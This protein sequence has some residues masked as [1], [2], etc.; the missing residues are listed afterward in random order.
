MPVYLPGLTFG[1]LGYGGASYGYSPYGSGVSP[2]L[3]VPVEGGYGG[4]PYGYASYGSVDITPPQATGANALDGYR[5]EVFFSEAMA[6]DAGLINPASYAFATTYGVSIST[7]SVAKGT[8]SGLGYSSVIVTHTGSTLGGQH[9]LTITGLT[10]VA[11]NPIGPSPANMVVFYALGDTA[12]A[13]ASLPLPDDGRS[14]QLDFQNSLGGAQAMLPEADF[15][16][17]V[18][19]LT[20]YVISTTYPVAPVIGSATQ[21]LALPSRVDLDVH[22]MTSAVYDL[23]LGPSL[24]FDYSGVLLPDDDPTLTGVEVGTGTSV[25]TMSDGLLLTKAVGVQYG[26]SFGDTTGRM[27][28]GTT[29][30]MDF[31]FDLTGTSIVPAVFNSTLATMS[32]SDG[33]IQVDL[34]L[35]DSAG[36]KT[37]TI[38]SGAYSATVLAAWDT[39]GEHTV[40][41]ARN[42]KGVFYTVLF[43]GEPLNTFA[44]ASA[45]GAAVFGPGAAFVLGTAHTV[46]VFKLKEI[47][48]TA[49]STL[50]TSAWNFIHGLTAPFTGSAVLTRDKIVTRYGPLVRG[51]GDNTPATKEDVEVR[52]DGGAIDLAG[53]N[54]YIGE[55]YP[56]IPIPLAVAGTITV[57]VDYIWFM[58][59]AM[60]L[61]GLN[62]QGLTLN[63]WDRSQGHTAGVPS[64]LPDGATGTVKTNRFPMGVAL[65]PYR[66]ESPKQ[67]GHK[68]IGW[69]KGGYSAL[70]NQPTTL[71]L[72]QNPHAIGV[73]GLSAD[74]LR[75]SGVFN[76]QTT[77]PNAETPWTLD[78]VDDGNV[79][80]DGTYRVIDASTGPY[81]VGTAAIYKR[82]LDLSLDIQVTDISRFRVDSYTAD[83]VY[84]G[85][86][87]GFHDGAHLVVVG[88]LLVD[89]VQHVGVLLDGTK[90]H[91]EEGWQIGPS[92]AGTATSTTTITVAFS[93]LP[94]GIE[95]GGRFRIAVGPQAG[96]YTIETCGLSL[97][98]DGTE[99][100]ITFSPA[101]P[102]D[103]ATFG[104]GAVTLL[105]ETLWNVGL[106]SFRVYSSFPTGSAAVYLGGSISGLVADLAE[107]APY[108]A[109][110]A[111]LLPA[112]EKGVMFWGSLSR[113][114]QSTSVW[115]LTQYLANPSQITNTVQGVTALTEMNTLPEDDPNDPWYRVGNFGTSQV[116]I[117]GDQLLL[118][119][120][121][122]DS[123]IPVEFTYER[124]EPYLT[125][126]VRTDAEATLLVE[127]GILG[128]GNASYRLRDTLRQSLLTTLHYVANTTQRQLIPTRPN[129]SLSG[130]QSPVG[131]GWTANPGNTTA[132]PFVRGQ[133]LELSKTSTQTAQWS[134]NADFGTLVDDEGLILESRFSVQSHTSGTR[135][136][137]IAIGGSCALAS[138]GFRRIVYLTLGTGTV[139]LRDSAYAVVQSFAFAWDDGGFHAYRLLCDPVAD[140]VVLVIDD[141]IVGSTPFAGFAPDATTTYLT[142]ALELT[143]DGACAVTLDSMS[144]TPLRVVA[145]IIGGI[146]QVID[147]TFGVYLRRTPTGGDPSVDDINSYRIP[148]LDGTNAL[149][150]SLFATAVPMDW[151]AFCRVRM[152]LDPNWGLSVYRPD[153]PLPPG[154]PGTALPSETTDP[155][156]AWINV[157]Y[158]D[159]PAYESRRGSVAFGALDSR[160]ISQ[161]RWDSVRYRIRGAPDGFGLAPQNMVLNRAFT[162]SSGEYN[163]DTTPEVATITSRTP[164][165]VYVPDSAIFADRVFVVQ[166]DGAV[167][168]PLLYSFDKITQD[169]K[170]DVSSPLPSDQHPVTVTFAVGKPVTQEYLCN[171]PLEETVTVLNEGTPPIPSDLDQPAER[172]VVAGSKI[173]DPNDVLDDAESLVLNDPLRVVTF[174]DDEDSLYADLQFCETED[175]D[176]VHITTICDGPGPGQGLAALEIDG[177]F[178]TDVH[179]VPG[180]P[181][182]PWRGSPTIKGSA[183]HFNQSKILTASGGFILGGNLGPGTAIL[184]PNQRGPS[185]EVPEGGM[186]INQDFAFRLDDVTPRA[187]TFDIQSVLS[188]NV[189][190]TSADPTV[191]P[192]PDA[193]ATI[194]GN[195]GAAYELVD[196]AAVTASRLGP[197]GGLTALQ[198]HSLLAG[199]SQLNGTEFILE[200][201]QQIVAPTVTTGFIRAAN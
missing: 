105:F 15:S 195:G 132:A 41:L 161:T 12:T 172:T 72:N 183:S 86:G 80:G 28:P 140:I 87:F 134:Q 129:V 130:L 185:G 18:D 136:I 153:L 34:T 170:F 43:D 143:G 150:S 107:V 177:H 48:N 196:Y 5:V 25:A 10:D 103:P 53:V 67:I 123:T 66:R 38:T 16:P 33:A 171:Q 131:A 109:Q 62:T 4:A 155:A 179:A 21:E 117:T 49:S 197:W 182:G 31:K 93:D 175:G 186:G 26:W 56:A 158:G 20:S 165:L 89:G 30:R 79:V 50:F 96:V 127:S 156:A 192:N 201:G 128:A 148:R 57:D 101:L 64:P 154:A 85:V 75:A 61:V 24:A 194:N 178:T 166:V 78:G 65:G 122:G 17:G 40:S 138:T 124:V 32:V 97:T 39:L 113:R 42:Q 73:G 8:A 152:Y 91:L 200:G 146:P 6:D 188:D 191:D 198:A 37:I 88:A 59:P 2:R 71:L 27:I 181:A 46:S 162:L 164:Y 112:T 102:T 190:P 60:E 35:S 68:Y 69:Q 159:L 114:A 55:I 145:R 149:N 168:S 22:P 199:G 58:N 104:A 141:A 133:T 169:L 23:T 52:L 187:D 45:T 126:K 76:G 54:P 98:E 180:G 47:K 115:D 139:D 95:P 92:V 193:A 120:T 111:L 137:G 74:A 63:T 106:I 163:L 157:E 108:P 167:V 14:V 176:S 84:T 119:A 9:T 7:V 44:V 51:W 100:G 81:G 3:P 1:G 121:S 99:V 13:T 174:T 36:I 144:A 142:A 29:Y 110:T 94:S 116:D 189:P 11:G 19:S 118:K 125:P 135:G 77:P 147:R 82:D 151:T 160:A 90:T 173:N 83:G 184:Y 70:L